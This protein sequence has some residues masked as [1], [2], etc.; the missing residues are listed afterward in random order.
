ML[1]LLGVAVVVV[2]FAVRL[3]RCWWW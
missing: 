2:G 1:T 3:T